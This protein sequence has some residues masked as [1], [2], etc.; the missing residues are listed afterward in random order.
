M[1]ALKG[2]IV[3]VFR[4]ANGRDYTLSGISFW[5]AELTITGVVETGSGGQP[6]WRP[7]DDDSRIFAPN[8]KRPQVWLHRRMIGGPVWSI[9]PACTAREGDGLR[10]HLSRLMFGGNFAHTSDSRFKRLVG[11]YGATAIHDRVEEF[12]GA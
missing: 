7:L 9:I 4:P 5:S 12:P 10:S 6:G 3:D 2:L 1:D 11:F 8:E